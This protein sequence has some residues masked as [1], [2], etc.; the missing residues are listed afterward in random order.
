MKNLAFSLFFLITSQVSLQACWFFDPDEAYYHFYEAGFVQDSSL[1][2]FASNSPYFSYELGK[3]IDPNFEDWLAYLG[4]KSSVVSEL[5]ALFFDSEGQTSDF[6]TWAK[7]KIN[8]DLPSL[9][10]ALNKQPNKQAFLPYLAFA[11]ACEAQVAQPAVDD[12][13]GQ[14]LRDPSLMRRLYEQALKA[15]AQAQEPFLARRYAFQALRLLHYLGDYRE[16][17]NLADKYLKKYENTKDY[18]YYRLKEHRAGVLNQLGR[19]AEA[20]YAFAQLFDQFPARRD[21]ALL[22]FEQV[23]GQGVQEETLMQLAQTPREKAM[24]HVLRAFSPQANLRYELEQIF[25]LDAE[26]PYLEVLVT[27]CFLKAQAKFFP[28]YE[29]I[30]QYPSISRAVDSDLMQFRPFLAKLQK[31]QAQRDFWPH[32]SAFLELLLRNPKGIDQALEQ[33][34]SQSPR[35]ARVENLAFV[36]Y[37]CNLSYLD[38]ET[39]AQAMEKLQNLERKG[40]LQHQTVELMRDIFASLYRRQGQQAKAF[41]IHNQL[42]QLDCYADKKLLKEIQT[43]IEQIAKPNALENQLWGDRTQALQTLTWYQARHH[44]QIGEY[45]QALSFYQALPPAFLAQDTAFYSSRISSRIFGAPTRDAAISIEADYEKWAQ[46]YRNLES[47]P[48]YYRRFD[49]RA[50]YAKFFKGQTLKNQLDLLQFLAQLSKQAQEIKG[51]EAA[52]AA[53]LLG[54]AMLELSPYGW[55]RRIFYKS[56][57]RDY[58]T[59]YFHGLDL[60]AR[61]SVFYYKN[62]SCVNTWSPQTITQFLNLAISKTKNPELAAEAHFLLARLA[63]FEDSLEYGYPTVN[64]NPEQYKI[65]VERYANTKYFKEIIRECS[66]LADYYR[67]R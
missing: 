51:E 49:Q 52:Q 8:K 26:N 47:N 10:A 1:I 31:A 17:L 29:V 21:V 14:P 4:L 28:R 50:E 22:S 60:Q 41:L 63:L 44:A 62:L 24:I 6:E 5:E 23:G 58:M 12:W 19:K 43:L 48:A 46:S 35:R 55:H 38:R 30:N 2:P 64:G 36:A 40:E 56:Q 27:R 15:E 66:D 9:A 67:Q 32:A 61:N 3:T 45:E 16:A 65:L 18:S 7:A 54:A 33:L 53:L 20:L 57:E 42:S 13:T 11:K 39:E 59:Y 25:E 34:P 37:L